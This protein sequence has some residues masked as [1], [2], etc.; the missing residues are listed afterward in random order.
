MLQVIQ[1]KMSLLGLSAIHLQQH[2]EGSN[3]KRELYLGFFA[4]SLLLP[5]QCWAAFNYRNNSS[6]PQQQRNFY[7][8]R[9][10]GYPRVAAS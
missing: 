7:P 2:L 4:C 8:C 6:S 5:S 3:N 10:V 9:K 1:E